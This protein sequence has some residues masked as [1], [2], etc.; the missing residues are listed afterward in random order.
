LFEYT[1]MMK[2]ATSI[3]IPH[4]GNNALGCLMNL[5]LEA[6]LTPRE[7]TIIKALMDMEATSLNDQVRKSVYTTLGITR[8]NLNNMLLRMQAKGVFDKEWNL[9]ERLLPLMGYKYLK[10]IIIRL[11][12]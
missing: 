8:E 2:P 12:A 10:H 11:K 4:Y 3:I 1:V 7:V 5:V 6:T 9:S